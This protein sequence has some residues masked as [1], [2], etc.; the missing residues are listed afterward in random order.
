MIQMSECAEA[1]EYWATFIFLVMNTFH[2][3]PEICLC[4]DSKEIGK[5]TDRA[6]SQEI[7]FLFSRNE[8]MIFFLERLYDFR[9]DVCGV[10]SCGI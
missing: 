10:V 7:C 3:A 5:S 2:P 4:S 8:L 1:G 6:F 9:E